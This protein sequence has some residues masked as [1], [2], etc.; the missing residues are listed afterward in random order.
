MTQ[1][2]IQL[3]RDL[4]TRRHG[5]GQ[6]ALARNAFRA[7]TVRLDHARYHFLELKRLLREHIDDKLVEQNL[8]DVALPGSEGWDVLQDGLIKVEAHMIACAQSVHA[9]PDALAH[10]AFYAA[11]LNFAQKPLSEEKI[12]LKTLL[13]TSALIAVGHGTVQQ[14]LRELADDPSFAA[15]E[16]VVNYAK[17]RGLPDPALQLEPEDHPTPYAMQFE[18]FSYGGIVRPRVEVERLLAPAYVAVSHAVVRTGN[19]INACLT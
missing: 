4:I 14:S 1:W 10:I 6:L 12:P 3:S 9:V 13:A 19:A 5:A 11:G 8:Y 16:A 7:A 15:L 2:H 17:H 18:S